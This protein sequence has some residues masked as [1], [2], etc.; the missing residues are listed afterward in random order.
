[1]LAIDEGL[2]DMERVRDFVPELP[3]L[4][5]SALALHR[6]RLPRDARLVLVDPR[7]GRR[8][9]GRAE[10]VDCGEGRGVPR[11][12]HARS[13]RSR[14]RPRGRARPDRAGLP[15]ARD[16]AADVVTVAIVGA[17]FM[18]SAHA[19]NYAALGGS[20]TGEGGLRAERRAGRT[21]R[22]DRGRRADGRPRLGPLRPGRPGG[23]R[24]RADPA[25]SRR[26]RARLRGG[27]A[28]LRREAARAHTRRRRRD[29]RDGRAER[30][31]ADGR[32]RAA[33]LAG[34]RRARAHPRVG[35]ARSAA[36]GLGPAPLPA[37]G[38]GRL[39]RRP[40]AVRGRLPS[41]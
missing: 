16:R 24:L 38:L 6:S 23:R 9:L 30:A 12:V 18:G 22:R 8:R 4:R 10:R 2:C 19:G 1:M 27:E 7:G 17:G 3:R 33:V 15:A 36:R 37:G 39:A 28:C 5:T 25:P 11:L 14:A 20:R 31:D 32:P 40:G 41:I 29:P 26:R 13:R 21:C 35:R 34:V